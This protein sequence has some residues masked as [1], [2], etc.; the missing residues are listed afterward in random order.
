[1]KH[2]IYFGAEHCVQCRAAPPRF[3]E[4]VT[5]LQ[6]TNYDI[7]DTDDDSASDLLGKYGIRSIP[8]IVIEDED[9]AV[10]KGHAL[11][12]IPKLKDLLK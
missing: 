2:I 12:I 8:T 10:T 11:E 6:F 1:M 3:K 5:K 9:G 4:E 7:V